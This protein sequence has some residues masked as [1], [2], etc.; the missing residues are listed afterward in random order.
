[1]RPLG[2]PGRPVPSRSKLLKPVQNRSNRPSPHCKPFQTRSNLFQ[3]PTQSNLFETVPTKRVPTF[4]R[5]VQPVPTRS[6]LFHFQPLP[7]CSNPV[8]PAPPCSNLFQPAQRPSNR[9]QPVPTCP[10]LFQPVPT[11]SN[12]FRTGSTAAT[13]PGA[14]LWLQRFAMPLRRNGYRR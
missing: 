12:L 7:T 5:P 13:K 6:N 10:N 9:I 1:M 4:S 11:R 2:T 8:P 14:D 3:L